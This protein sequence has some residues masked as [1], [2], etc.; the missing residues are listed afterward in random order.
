MTLKEYNEVTGN[1]DLQEPCA[2]CKKRSAEIIW[3]YYQIDFDLKLCCKCAT[4]H[5]LAILRD[6]AEIE[7]GNDRAHARYLDALSRI[8]L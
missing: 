7:V 6:V 4:H 5:A 2:N 1:G 3:T 8:G